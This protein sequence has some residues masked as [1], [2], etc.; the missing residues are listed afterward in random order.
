MIRIQ[1]INLNA[2][3]I[4]ISEYQNLGINMHSFCSQI[5]FLVIYS[6]EIIEQIPQSYI[7]FMVLKF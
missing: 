6:K 7:E 3:S 2:S 5:S 1:E 4:I